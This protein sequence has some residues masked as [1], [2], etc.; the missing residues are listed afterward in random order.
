MIYKWQLNFFKNGE[1]ELFDMQLVCFLHLKIRYLHLHKIL[2]PNALFGKE[3]SK[4][5]WS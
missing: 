5:L 1:V 4:I 3:Q 2:E